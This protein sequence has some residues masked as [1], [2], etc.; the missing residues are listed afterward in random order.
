MGDIGPGMLYVAEDDGS[1][2]ILVTPEAL[3]GIES[4][5]VLSGRG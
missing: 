3:P 1:N 2:P 4:Y 5:H